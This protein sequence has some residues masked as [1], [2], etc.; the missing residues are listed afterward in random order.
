MREKPERA[1]IPTSVRYVFIKKISNL[2]QTAMNATDCTCAE[3]WKA[4]ES[5]DELGTHAILRGHHHIDWIRAIMDLYRC[6]QI[7]PGHAHCRNRTPFDM[8]VLLVESSW[9]LFNRIWS[10]RNSILHNNDSYAAKTEHSKLLKAL[11][12][13]KENRHTL[14]HYRDRE[15]IDIPHGVIATWD[16]KRRRKMISVLTDLSTQYKKELQLQ[17]ESQPTLKAFGFTLLRRRRNDAN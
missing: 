16:R 8:S 10:M 1:N 6:R 14:L 4:I 11:Y 7:P 12:H 3:A 15:L 9:T 5:Q 2:T 13:F 17:S